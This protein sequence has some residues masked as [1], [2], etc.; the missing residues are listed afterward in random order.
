MR[1]PGTPRGNG[2]NTHETDPL[3]QAW[4]NRRP[5]Q[6]AIPLVANTPPP[7]PLWL[8]YDRFKGQRDKG[9]CQKLSLNLRPMKA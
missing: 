5:L 8:R 1:H 6:P 4:P 3:E 9:V 7:A 2:R